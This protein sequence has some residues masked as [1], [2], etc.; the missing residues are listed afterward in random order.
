MNASVFAAAALVASLIAS[1]AEAKTYKVSLGPQAQAEL[2]GV[3]Q[4]AQ[5]GDQIRF[6]KGRYEFTRPVTF[7]ATGITLRGAGPDAT[8]FSFLGQ[9]DT[10][11]CLTFT[12]AQVT[13]RDFA[14]ENCKGD[15]ITARGAVQLTV[16]NLRA[17]WAGARPAAVSGVHVTGAQGV[18]FENVIVRGASFAG[19][20][21]ARSRTVVVRDS[22]VAGNAIGIAIENTTGADL[23]RNG[24]SH[25]AVGV[26]VY[27]LPGAPGGSLTRVFKNQITANDG[28]A[29]AGETFAN[30]APAG[31]GVLLTATRDVVLTDND[32]GE[33]PGANVFIGAYRGTM[34]DANYNA[35]PR[36]VAIKK[37]RFG[38]SGFA[39]TGE[40]AAIAK[41]GAKP[42]DIIWDGVDTFFAGGSPHQAP[43]LLAI[44]ENRATPGPVPSFVNLGLISAGADWTEVQPKTAPAPVSNVPDVP[45]V[46]LPRGM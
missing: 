37:N 39:P 32:I 12:G 44:E 40:I 14:V 35:L 17:E 26:A 31:V 45:E 23:F 1:A 7:A 27:D 42:A 43:V 16:M 20:R 36:N 46:K 3:A 11:T 5:T 4:Q 24:A 10:N 15:A 22:V 6:D 34:E 33:N 2:T 25:N 38:R 8:A 19:I 29:V 18:L 28:Q 41:A 13:L 9:T 21:V 30:R